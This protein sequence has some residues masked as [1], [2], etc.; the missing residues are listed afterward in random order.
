MQLRTCLVVL[1]LPPYS[2]GLIALLLLH[3]QSGHSLAVQGR[4][5][6]L[7]EEEG[8]GLAA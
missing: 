7:W 6:D 8:P 4:G 2:L 5:T 3:L 1:T